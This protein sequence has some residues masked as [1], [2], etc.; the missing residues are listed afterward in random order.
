MAGI[1]RKAFGS[2]FV[3]AGIVLLLAGIAAAGYGYYDQQEH[4]EEWGPGG[5]GEDPDRTD[6]NQ[7]LQAGGAVGAGVGLVL[8]IIGAVG[9]SS[10]REARRLQIQKEMA[11]SMGGLSKSLEAVEPVEATAK[12]EVVA[13]HTQET[14]AVREDG[15]PK[16]LVPVAA[17]VGVLLVAILLVMASGGGG[18]GI[19]GDDGLFGSKEDKAMATFERSHEFGPTLTV[20]GQSFSQAV[21]GNELPSA[22]GAS[23]LR[24][25]AAWVPADN[26]AQSIRVLLQ[27]QVDGVWTDVE[28]VVLLP[29]GTT[30]VSHAVQNPMRYQV[31]PGEDGLVQEQTFAIQIEFW[32]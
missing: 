23:L 11:R 9:V 5:L 25:S 6:Q 20:G 31:Y 17:G 15:R 1:G 27:E 19:L 4:E 10:G 30:D 21:Q 8:L 22:T 13:T 14:E 32:A 16:W 28:D 7:A 29:G 26:G 12:N 24:V 18:G 2:I 3:M